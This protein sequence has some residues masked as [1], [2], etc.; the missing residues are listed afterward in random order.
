MAKKQ[1]ISKEDQA[2]LDAYNSSVS[3]GDHDSAQ[4]QLDSYNESLKKKGPS[5]STVKSTNGASPLD[6]ILKSGESK[7]YDQV[8]NGTSDEN[9]PAEQKPIKQ[10]QKDPYAEFKQPKPIGSETTQ[11]SSNIIPIDLEADK[12]ERELRVENQK[13][14]DAETTGT[15]IISKQ[16][17]Q[18]AKMSEDERADY[19]D[20]LK[21]QGIR[22]EDINKKLTEADNFYYKKLGQ[23]QYDKEFYQKKSALEKAGISGVDAVKGAREAMGQSNLDQAMKM[24]DESDPENSKVIHDYYKLVDEYHSGKLTPENKYES[25]QK[26]A[27]LGAKLQKIGDTEGHQFVDPLTGEYSKE[28]TDKVKVESDAIK[29][30]GN[31]IQQIKKLHQEKLNEFRAIEAKM[32]ENNGVGMTNSEAAIKFP[33][34]APGQYSGQQE[35]EINRSKKLA[36]D[37]RQKRAELEA[38]NRFVLLN[39]SPKDIKRG[40]FDINIPYVGHLTG[41][42]LKSAGEGLMESFGNDVQSSTEQIANTGKLLN[43]AGINVPEEAIK[44]GEKTFSQDIGEMAGMIPR[45]ALELE[46]TGNIL[47]AVNELSG[48]AK[49]GEALELLAKGGQQVRTSSGV[50][51][52]TDRI[53]RP[54]AYRVLSSAREGY[55]KFALAPDENLTGSA[56]A[57][58]GAVEGMLGNITDITGKYGK[59]FGT[60]LRVGAGAI[61]E[62]TGEIVG[63]MTQDLSDAGFD[64]NKMKNPLGETGDEQVDNFSKIFMLSLMGSTAA[65][66]PALIFARNEVKK[67]GNDKMANEMTDLAKE[68]GIDLDAKEEKIKT[69]DNDQKNE[70]GVQGDLGEGQ[71]SKQPESNESTGGEKTEAGGIL[72]TQKGV[73]TPLTEEKLNFKAESEDHLQ[74]IHD[75]LDELD[76]HLTTRL[77]ESA[78]DIGRVIVLNGAKLVL[79]AAKASVKVGMS[80]RDAINYGIDQVKKSDWYK[81]LNVDEKNNFNENI[82]EHFDNPKIPVGKFDVPMEVYNESGK[83]VLAEKERGQSDISSVHAGL[84]HVQ[85]SDWYKGLSEEDQN[86]FDN[87]Y[88]NNSEKF[89]QSP[90]RIKKEKDTSLAVTMTEKEGLVKQI[91]DFSK[92]YKEAQSKANTEKDKAT[93]LEKRRVNKSYDIG[94][95]VGD[96]IGRIKATKEIAKSSKKENVNKE[97]IKKVFDEGLKDLDGKLN[98]KQIKSIMNKALKTD[99]ESNIKVSELNKHI[100]KIVGDV[101]YAV[102]K[103]EIDSLKSKIKN[104][105]S[106]KKI[107]FETK[108]LGNRLKNINPD[109]V[110]EHDV[111]HKALTDFRSATTGGGS[112]EGIEAI[113]SKL[114]EEQQ[115]NKEKDLDDHYTDLYSKFITKEHYMSFDDFKNMLKGEETEKQKLA[116][117]KQEAEALSGVSK[118]SKRRQLLESVS[119]FRLDDLSKYLEEK[120]GTLDSKRKSII[121]NFLKI[122]NGFDISKLSNVQLVDLNNIVDNI[123]LND[124]F[125]KSGSL[126]SIIEGAKKAEQIKQ[127]LPK[128]IKTKTIEG[129]IASAVPLNAKFRAIAGGQQAGAEIYSMIAGAYNY[130]A[131]IA[132]SV[133]SEFKEKLTQLYG[134]LKNPS[135]SNFKIGMLADLIQTPKGLDANERQSFFEEKKQYIEDSIKYLKSQEESEYKEYGNKLEEIYNAIKYIDNHSDLVKEMTQGDLFSPQEKAIWNHVIDFNESKKDEYSFVKESYDNEPFEESDFYTGTLKKN[136]NRGM[137]S[138]DDLINKNKNILNKNIKTKIGG[139]TKKRV[140]PSLITIGNIPNYDFYGVTDFRTKDMLNDIHTLK[141]RYVMQNMFNS[142][143]FRSMFSGKTRTMETPFRKV[144]AGLIDNH[145]AQTGSFLKDTNFAYKVAMDTFRNIKGSVLTTPTQLFKQPTVLIHSMSLTNPYDILNA[146]AQYI[147]SSTDKINELLKGSDASRRTP[148][149]DIAFS[150]SARQMSENVGKRTYRKAGS[151]LDY[152]RTFTGSNALK[153]SDDMANKLS[154]M[155]FMANQLRKEG[156]IGVNWSVD[157]LLK[158]KTPELVAK[159][160]MLSA[161]VNGES[162]TAKLGKLFKKNTGL[163]KSENA[164]GNA[165]KEMLLSFKSFSMNSAV[166]FGVNANLMFSSK[167][168]KIVAARS[169]LGLM[170]SA[171]LFAGVK[172]LLKEEKEQIIGSIYGDEEKDEEK[173]TIDQLMKRS[174]V[175]G[176]VDLLSSPLPIGEGLVKKAGGTVYTS[177]M[178]DDKEGQKGFYS[179]QSDLLG[180]FQTTSQVVSSGVDLSSK[181]IDPIEEHSDEYFNMTPKEQKKEKKEKEIKESDKWAYGSAA[182]S[183]FGLGGVR[184]ALEAVKKRE[185]KKEKENAH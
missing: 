58:E 122:N 149:G 40:F 72:Q 16:K 94:H 143:D 28:Y 33:S 87:D 172:E 162:D 113:V 109:Y 52:K 26:I 103:S 106:G 140:S 70:S 176:A 155:A 10:T 61:G 170:A 165:A 93:S 128:F 173:L 32:N 23:E 102:K 125:S 169:M 4:A 132:D 30:S 82:Q 35:Q 24:L 48:A 73:A 79:K 60:I 5:D 139:G 183:I 86:N 100:E 50:I 101:N 156:K 182:A 13:K 71:E 117:E 45:F 135:E 90:K 142:P 7:A 185:K 119:K 154:F 84:K 38:L 114:E 145:N 105:T 19:A 164:F 53:L 9:I 126:S 80:T 47:G 69:Q 148:F 175:G 17:E 107:P 92:G 98:P 88:L 20:K 34:L 152:T 75:T 68:N 29:A 43:E 8:T 77:N 146:H 111:L 81:N 91:K 3:Q 14:I 97:N 59:V 96:L 15:N 160:D 163:D 129:K 57:G 67:S 133:H 137:E 46:A 78:N 180:S 153:W 171:F 147:A 95:A 83:T 99:F 144:M 178:P 127:F 12:K 159:A 89:L 76:K 141:D 41:E 104:I 151:A 138:E 22:E 158:H 51:T 168:G 110:N 1:N 66:V 112:I 42:S 131:R 115:I 11:Q 21:E 27:E 121:D 177:L 124:S 157:D 2:A 31:T 150:K 120:K 65:N 55:A 174:A 134:D 64:V 123:T 108:D 63:Q 56:G 166:N 118:P 136:T 49:A 161:Q 85:R 25:A 6:S 39:E 37:Y 184:E 116:A 130:G 74:N 18:L 44:A 167:D 54:F 181:L 36:A 62:T 179:K